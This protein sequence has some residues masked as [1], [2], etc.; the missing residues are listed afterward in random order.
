M[1]KPLTPE[2]MRAVP[3]D[4]LTDVERLLLDDN[5]RAEKEIAKITQ[6]LAQI[7]IETK[8]LEEQ[9]NYQI[10]VFDYTIGLT[11]KRYT[12]RLKAEDQPK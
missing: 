10:G 3:K 12:D 9:R 6:R 8:R 1:M 7:S 5:E 4:Q 2:T 11:I